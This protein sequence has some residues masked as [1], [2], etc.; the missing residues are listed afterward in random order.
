ML[1]IGKLLPVG[2]RKTVMK[3]GMGNLPV[4]GERT[5]EGPDRCSDG[6]LLRSRLSV[7]FHVAVFRCIMVVSCFLIKTLPRAIRRAFEVLK[8]FPDTFSSPVHCTSLYTIEKRIA[9]S[10][11]PVII[12]TVVLLADTGSV[13]STVSTNV[14]YYAPGS[15]MNGVVLNPV[16]LVVNNEMVRGRRL[17]PYCNSFTAGYWSDKLA[18]TPYREMFSI[19][20]SGQWKLLI[21][22]LI[23]E[24]FGV[25]GKTAE[26]TS[27]KITEKVRGGMSLFGSS[28]VLLLGMVL[29]TVALDV[30]VRTDLQTDLPDAPF[31]ILFSE[32]EGIRHGANLSLSHMGAQLRVITDITAYYGLYIDLS[33]I[34]DRCNEITGFTDF[35]KVSWGGGLTA[36]IG[37]CFLDMKTIDGGIRMNEDGTGIRID[38]DMNLKTAGTGLSGKWRFESPLENGIPV[39]GG[40]AGIDVGVLMYG[41]RTSIG[42]TLRRLGFMYWKDVQEADITI[43]TRNLST[44]D[45]IAAELSDKRY[46]LFDTSEGGY[47]PDP[48]KGDSLHG[49]AALLQWQPAR[50]GFR[51]G[52]QINRKNTMD[53]RVCAFSRYIKTTFEYEQSIIRWPGRSFFPRLAL[54]VENGFLW[55]ALPVTIGI[56]LGG[57][58]KIASSAGFTIGIRYFHLQFGYQAIGTPYWYP[59]RGMRAAF[60][61]CTEWIGRAHQKKK[62][63]AER[64]D[65]S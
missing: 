5:E 38:A 65:D 42:I 16:M 20:K 33:R 34:T 18:L 19:Y 8:P 54:D 2:K 56:I 61:L 39:V 63:A 26:K 53:S 36:S 51:F 30:R 52:Y 11:I 49:D 13:P 43:R 7:V 55:G 59:K 24:S 47:F 41:D 29:N 50:A 6:G 27:R 9:L 37:N 21:T 22:R 31:L 46:D 10:L 4:Y 32:D 40:G 57:A 17:L 25:T 64:N 48:E 14:S 23:N 12:G 28:D 62:C 1:A 35:E 60:G 15:G 3:S 44:A 58:E 45:F